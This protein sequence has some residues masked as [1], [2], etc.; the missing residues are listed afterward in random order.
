MKWALLRSA[1]LRTWGLALQVAATLFLAAAA[2]AA[3][4]ALL[5]VERD[6]LRR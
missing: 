3:Q 2:A 1:T 5:D 4:S 6:D